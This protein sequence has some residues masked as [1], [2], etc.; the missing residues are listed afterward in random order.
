MAATGGCRATRDGF[1]CTRKAGHAGRHI[2]RGI[3]GMIL[4]IWA[5]VKR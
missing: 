5:R 1:A 3:D 2:A 4:K